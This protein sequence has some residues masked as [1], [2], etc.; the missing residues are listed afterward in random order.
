MGE[1]VIV[2][3]AYSDRLTFA[4]ALDAEAYRHVECMRSADAKEAAMAFLEKRPPVF[5][6]PDER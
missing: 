3:A 4:E 1:P 2:A 5:T 6:S